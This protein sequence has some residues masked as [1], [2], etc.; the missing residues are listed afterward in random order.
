MLSPAAVI[1]AREE[2]AG[3]ALAGFVEAFGAMAEAVERGDMP[4]ARAQAEIAIAA[5]A[6]AGQPEQEVA[7]ALC[8]AGAELREGLHDRAATAYRAGILAAR[9]V[10]PDR[11]AEADVLEATA[12][13]GL[14]GVL[15]DAQRQAEAARVFAAAAPVFE[16]AGAGG[17]AF[18]AMRL[19][20][21]CHMEVAA[22]TEAW[23]C[24]LQ[25]L[26]LAERLPDAARP[27]GAIADLHRLLQVLLDRH[28]PRESG[29][30]ATLRARV[31]AMLGEAGD[32]PPLV[33]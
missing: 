19:A 33:A 12:A 21:S 1:Q 28:Y 18:L 31:G 5:A 27:R 26:E 22:D 4:A 23:R 10:P 2:Q 3:A 25:A 30:A 13:L 16:R 24:G 6:A 11:R 32:A 20:T 14:G 29:F 15:A 7:A 8:L 9:R 17:Q